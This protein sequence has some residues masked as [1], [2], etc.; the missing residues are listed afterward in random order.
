[1]TQQNLPA[2][3]LRES[4]LPTVTQQKCSC[5]RGMRKSRLSTPQA[6]RGLPPA[7]AARRHRQP[8]WKTEVVWA[9]G[10]G[11]VC[12]GSDN[13]AELRPQLR[14]GVCVGGSHLSW[15]VF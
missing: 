10:W 12:Q 7:A 5:A 6:P 2:L 8:A 11:P 14:L 15:T 13:E 1:M 3:C 4:L 9:A